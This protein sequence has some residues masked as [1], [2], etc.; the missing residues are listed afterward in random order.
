MGITD[1]FAG[2]IL[3]AAYCKNKWTRVHNKVI[4]RA[5]S[6]RTACNYKA[7]KH[8]GQVAHGQKLNTVKQNTYAVESLVTTSPE[9]STLQSNTG[10]L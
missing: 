2:L 3:C 7:G 8:R 10:Y 9:H 4:Q 6:A 1:I 5:Q